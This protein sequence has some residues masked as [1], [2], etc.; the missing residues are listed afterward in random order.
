MATAAEILF[1]RALRGHIYVRRVQEGDR[2]FLVF[3]KGTA[4]R[5]EQ[6]YKFELVGDTLTLVE[7]EHAMPGNRP[8]PASA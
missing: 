8:E 4:H 3:W 1:N 2:T 5:M 7:P 6:Q